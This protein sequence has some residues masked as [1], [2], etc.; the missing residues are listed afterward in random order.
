M[1]E[2]ERAVPSRHG[3]GISRQRAGQSHATYWHFVCLT[4]EAWGRRTH[5][6]AAKLLRE[7]PNLWP[8]SCYGGRPPGPARSLAGQ[9]ARRDGTT[10][11]AR[12]KSRLERR[13][14]TDRN[15][16][17]RLVPSMQMP[18]LGCTTKTPWSRPRSHAIAGRLERRPSTWASAG[19]DPPRR[20][21]RTR[22]VE[23]G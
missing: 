17:K 12:R 13:L 16:L 19:R 3:E 4:S 20:I 21:L 15:A 6:K 18:A 9:K 1:R 22:C 5:P 14:G 23:H 7:T 2:S 8:L 10:P 11:A